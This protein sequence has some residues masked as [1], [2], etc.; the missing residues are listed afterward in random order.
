MPKNQENPTENPA[1]SW[2][3]ERERKE[4]SMIHLRKMMLDELQRRNYS[5]H[6]AEAYIRAL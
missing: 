1:N 5:K 2:V 6:T 4:I 3:T